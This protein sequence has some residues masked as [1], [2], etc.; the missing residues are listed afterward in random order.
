M[1]CPVCDYNKYRYVYY[2]EWGWGTVE[3]HG[4]CERCGY[5]VEQAYSETIVGFTLPAR[6][7]WRDRFGKYHEKNIRKRKRMKRKYNIKYS[8]EDW[9]LNFI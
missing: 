6:R 2:T 3:Q 7:G 4:Y 5:T 1:N 9:M 8:N